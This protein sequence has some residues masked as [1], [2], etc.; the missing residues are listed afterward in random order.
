MRICML[1]ALAVVLT[2]GVSFAYPG[3]AAAFSTLATWK[4]SEFTHNIRGEKQIMAPPSQPP[5]PPPEPD[6]NGRD[7][8]AEVESPHRSEAGRESPDPEKGVDWQVV[9]GVVGIIGIVVVVFFGWLNDKSSRETTEALEKI[10]ENTAGI[11]SKDP[12]EAAATAARV[13]REPAA[14]LVD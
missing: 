10:A 12:D 13:Q 9:S 8:T 5:P 4:A 2:A 14:S 1:L 11:A 6:K 3:R 7:A